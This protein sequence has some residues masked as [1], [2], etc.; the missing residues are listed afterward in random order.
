M[1]RNFVCEESF[2]VQDH[3]QQLHDN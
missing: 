2:I 1:S 3:W